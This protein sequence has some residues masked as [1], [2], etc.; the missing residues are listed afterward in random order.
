MVVR[1]CALAISI[2]EWYVMVHSPVF[3]RSVWW[4]YIETRGDRW[5]YA[6]YL[7]K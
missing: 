2:E 7:L 6:R 5:R 3:Y 4:D 1:S